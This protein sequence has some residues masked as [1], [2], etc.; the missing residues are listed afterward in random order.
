MSP[1]RTIDWGTAQ[2][3]GE[4]VAGSPP[5]G[6]PPGRSVQP[7][8]HEFARRVSDYTGLD[9]PAELPPLEMVDRPSWIA[10]N[11]LTMRP[12]L[13][14]L[15]ERLGNEGTQDDDGAA[16]ERTDTREC[17]DEGEGEHEGDD[18]ATGNGGGV[19][20]LLSEQL[21]SI[22]GPLR[23]AW[24][25]L[26]SASGPLR[27]SASD[28][29]RAASGYML[30]AQ[31]GAVT[32]MLSQRVLGQYD[33]SL[34]DRSVP[35][36]LL[37][38]AP[39]LASAARNLG[40]DRD[41]LIAWVA[42]HEITHAVQF[43]GA[44]WLADHLGGILREL[45]D[46]LALGGAGR[47][48]NGG[49]LDEDSK[50][51]STR[52]DGPSWLPDPSAFDPRAL[53]DRAR[54]GELQTL[55]ERARRGELLRIGLG[56]ERW[57]LVERMQATMSLI[58]GHAEHTM[59]AVGAEFLPSLPRL[60]AALTRRRESRGLPWRVLERLLGLELKMRQYEVGR[61]FCDAVVDAGGP[62]TLAIAWRSPDEL[63]STAE[64]AE[65]ALWLERIRVPA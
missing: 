23:S 16:G 60:R 39:N 52:P 24:E 50:E 7:L 11:L 34:L 10:A 51:D 14:P 35:P 61:R 45:L 15:L 1:I 19:R 26:R 42:I 17:E 46:G 6:G 37:L 40:V 62:E 53:L 25:P 44:P 59:D 18:G 27:S 2:R 64:L 55:V 47:S 31:L 58:E 32:G 65:P 30:G 9:L 43:S 4:L 54:D 49:S 22:P 21:R 36:R 8:A 5:Y 48:A 63:P 28:Q 12:L 29:L 20:G 13:D 3:V 38:L 41:E 56:D 57:Q 33:V